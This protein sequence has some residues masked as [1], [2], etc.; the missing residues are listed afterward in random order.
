MSESSFS[1]ITIP[2]ELQ[3]LLRRWVTFH[4]VLWVLTLVLFFLA[5][6]RGLALLYG[7]F[8]LL[9]SLLLVSYL[10]P[11]WQL[12]NIGV[13]RSVASHF[14]AGRRGSI[15]YLLTSRHPRYHVELLESLEFAQISERH[16][17]FSKIAGR[18]SWQLQFDCLKRG[19]YRLG[20]C[21]LASAYPFGVVKATK[22]IDVEPI[23]IL[24]FP[25]VVD[26]QRIPMPQVADATTWGEVLVPEQGGRD[27]FTRVREYRQGDE[28]NR[29]HWPVSARHQN[30]VV[31]V[32]EKTDRPAMLLVLDSHGRFNA[33]EGH[34][35]TFEY[36]VTIAASMIRYATCEGIQCFLVAQGEALQEISVAAYCTDFFP[37]Y[38]L[39]A[40][41][42]CNGKHPYRPMVEQ[43]H[44]R[45]PQANLIVTFRLDSESAQP[46][47]SPNVTQIDI[48]MDQESFQVTQSL[49]VDRKWRREG[50]RLIYPLCADQKL[51][52][53]FQ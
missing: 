35:T 15:N 26:L 19:C 53:L 10:M 23:E 13:T 18:I 2:P 8:S 1:S 7:L 45:F 24:V 5:W 36:A 33:G 25:K 41:L 50:N 9:V 3:S 21:R 29:V 49:D 27:E 46:K 51:E 16:V 4:R 14:T 28:L 44:R 6:N 40:R 11:K 17:F 39:L 20:G 38:K 22:H 42:N 37:L 34:R 31:K 47:L 48:E 32:Y 12:R 52:T 43:A 30:L